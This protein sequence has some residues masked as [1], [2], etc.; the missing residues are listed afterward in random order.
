MHEMSLMNNLIS[1]IKTLAD[2]QGGAEVVGVHVWLGALSHISP[3]HFR[4]HFEQGTKGTLAE[5]AHLEIVTSN[6]IDD[7]NAQEILLQSIEVDD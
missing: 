3:D 6:D 4:D 5:R 1:K 7:P 2:E